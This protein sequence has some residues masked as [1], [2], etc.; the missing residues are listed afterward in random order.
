MPNI[1]QHVRAIRSEGRKVV[2]I[3]RDCKREPVVLEGVACSLTR[4]R[5]GTD[6]IIEGPPEHMQRA[7][8][9]LREIFPHLG[10]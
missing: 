9:Q 10:E 6:L 4:D 5:H 8:E 3:P 7:T 2:L 1:W